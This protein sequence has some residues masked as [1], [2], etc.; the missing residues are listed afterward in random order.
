MSSNESRSLADAEPRPLWLDGPRPLLRPSLEGDAEADLLVV[1]AG[2]TGL[3]AALLAAESD[4]GERVVLAEAEVIAH[5]A[6]G[7]NGGFLA[8]SLTHGVGN[9]LA[10]FP[11][12][13]ERL[14][15]LGRENYGAIEGFVASSGAE[16]GWDPTGVLNVATR[17]H[18]VDELR[19][20]EHLLRRFGWDAVFL[21]RD[22]VQAELA[23]PTYLAGV[24]ERDGNALV[25]P[26]RLAHS[27]AARAEELGVRI[28]EQTPVASIDERGSGVV[29]RTPFGTIRARRAIL[30]TSA[31][32]PLVRSIRRYVV[33]VY[34]YVLATEPLSG[35]QR[36]ALGWRNRQGIADSGN[37]FHYY[38]LTA[39]DR[40][41]WGGY[42]A[43]YH[44]R[45]GM[46][47]HLEAREA[48]FRTLARNFHATF[49]QLEGIRFTHRWAGA[50]DTCSRFCMTFGRALDGRAT[51]V[52]GFTGLGVGASRFGARVALDLAHG[53]DTELTRLRFVRS[54][55]IPFPP[56]PLRW[57]GITW[58]RR[59]LA[60]ADRDG[61]RGP[62][63]RTLDRLGLGFDS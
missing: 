5:G 23:S 16:V 55:P 48:S 38:R 43:V 14:E 9:G 44:F 57:L 24:W 13:I 25:D 60:R 42:D 36:A 35:E 34:D 4:P 11:D 50:I 63:L 2:L 32:P 39:D 31:F 19:E 54:K 61:R 3:W 20:L 7:R 51:Y 49:P 41:V 59:A 52:V 17:A 27:L 33:P 29:A 58:T 53:R 21:S 1:G 18:E 22:E 10:R 15:E 12:E 30:A 45:N 26:A 8:A 62:W 37:Q 40:I 56:E 46:A 28:H 47:P 6:T